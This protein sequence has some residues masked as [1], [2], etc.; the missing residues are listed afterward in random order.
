MARHVNGAYA[1]GGALRHG[2]RTWHS[3]QESHAAI[4][5]RSIIN[6]GTETLQNALRV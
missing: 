3:A 4:G 2:H 5:L 6:Q 1:H